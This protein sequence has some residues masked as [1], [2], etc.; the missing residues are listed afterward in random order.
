VA[1]SAGLCLLLAAFL[2]SCYNCLVIIEQTL[3]IPANHQLHVTVP[4]E[5]PAGE[6]ATVIVL[7]PGGAQTATP[8]S[9]TRIGFLKGRIA[10]P[11]DFDSIGQEETTTLFEGNP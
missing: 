8:H 7:A 6:T 10:V 3:T 2:F 1:P 11:A 4:P 9:P 5:F